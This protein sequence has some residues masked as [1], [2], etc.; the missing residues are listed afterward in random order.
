[1]GKVQERNPEKKTAEL[2]I[3]RV[4]HLAAQLGVTAA[5][6]LQVAEDA[7]NLYVDFS[8]D[9]KGKKR[10]LTMAKKPLDLIQRRILTRL[11]C[12]LPVSEHA[13]GAIKGR[14]IRGNAA[15]H[16]KAPFVAKLDIKSFYPS[17]R[18]EKI[19]DFFLYT[20][21]CSPDVASILTKLTTRKYALPLGTSTSPF[22]ADQIISPIDA[23]IGNMA[24]LHGLTYT[25]YV[26]DLTLSG[27]FDLTD[28]TKQLLRIIQQNGFKISRNKLVFYRP[29]DGQERIITGVMVKDGQVHAPAGY[30]EWLADELKQ[31]RDASRQSVTTGTFDTKAQYQGRIGYVMWLDPKQGIRLL[32]L[33]RKVQWKHLEHM[34][35]L[36]G[37]GK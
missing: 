9:V 5:K 20:Q 26:D 36:S 16:A 3:Q 27:P 32:H 13:Y 24:K 6:L 2:G 17:I 8:K 37:L 31:A 1:M 21:K 4:Q 35:T 18:H 34:A 19:F 25:R 11:L 23:R 28:Y 22:L 15:S 29:D 7:Q 30:V 10:D 12:R 14:G 33:F